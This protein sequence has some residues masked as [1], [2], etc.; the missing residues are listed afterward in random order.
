MGYRTT[1]SALFLATLTILLTFGHTAFAALPPNFSEVDPGKVYRG[2]QPRS[3]DFVTLA[4]DYKIKTIIDLRTGDVNEEKQ[5]AEALGMT[6]VSAPISAGVWDM[7]TSGAPDA[8]TVQLV[9]ST[10][11]DPAKQPVFIHCWRGS[12]RTG[13]TVA[14]YR[15]F[16]QK[17]T[18]KDAWNEMKHF[19]F[20]TFFGG[21]I[22]YF[23]QAT[24][25]DPRK[26]PD[27][28]PSEPSGFHEFELQ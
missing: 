28:L 24:G 1:K 26:D 22:D 4:I 16:T 27:Y 12:D 19:G 25:Y 7:I 17:W 6:V 9:E 8:R 23:A 21:F 3:P 11:S 20:S 18:P 13:L 14:L 10:L 15:V 5:Q 2:G